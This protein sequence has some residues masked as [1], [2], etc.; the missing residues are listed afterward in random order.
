MALS[1]SFY[2]IISHTVL[3]TYYITSGYL[4]IY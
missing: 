2:Q 3:S 1:S 4:N